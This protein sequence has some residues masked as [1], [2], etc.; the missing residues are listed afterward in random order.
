MYS[1]LLS[2]IEFGF[3][4]IKNRLKEIVNENMKVVVIP[5]AFPTELDYDRLVNEY[6]KEGEK[7]YNKYI[8]SL[9]ELGIQKENITILNCYEKDTS[10]FK[11]IINSADLLV[12]PGG[13]PINQIEI[14]NKINLKN[15]I[16]KAKVV[17][18]VSAGAINLSEEAIYFNDYS[19]KVE[20]YDGIGLTDINVYPHFDITNKDFVEEVKMV[21]RLKSLIALPNNSFIKI[22]DK[23]IEFI[24]D[25]FKVDK[26]NIIKIN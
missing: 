3:P 6:F 5:W 8:N 13:N 11:N 10:N 21:S 17:I 18:G 22:D 7:K 12:L 19:K 14:I 24:G 15:I 23:Q 2:K 26:E 9:L 4:L 1:V 20:M 25:S 16:N